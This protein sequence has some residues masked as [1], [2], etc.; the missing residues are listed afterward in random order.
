MPPSGCPRP[1]RPPARFSTSDYTVGG[2]A[3]LHAGFVTP[4]QAFAALE[5]TDGDVA[6]ALAAVEG[7]GVRAAGS[8]VVGDVTWQVGRA[9]QGTTTLTRR[10]TAGVHVGVSGGA[11]QAEL[12]QLVAA[13]R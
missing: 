13:L 10:T 3:L 4:S 1:G 5:E 11:S 9:R 8:V 7:A 2:R 12:E 6:G